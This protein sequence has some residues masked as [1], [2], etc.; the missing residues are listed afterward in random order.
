MTNPSTNAQTQNTSPNEYLTIDFSHRRPLCSN[1]TN[2]SFFI[3]SI[4]HFAYRAIGILEAIKKNDHDIACA[5]DAAISE[6]EDVRA[7]AIAYSEHEYLNKN[8]Q[9]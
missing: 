5:L 7:T 8:P 1:K 9:T 3:D 4:D 2:H 6:I